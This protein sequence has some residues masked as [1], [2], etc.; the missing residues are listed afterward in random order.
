MQFI[1]KYVMLGIAIENVTENET[2][3]SLKNIR[4]AIML[5]KRMSWLLAATM[6]A[7]MGM[8]CVPAAAEEST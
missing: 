3:N 8:G 4:R 6:V 1:K 5:K 7:S 2:G